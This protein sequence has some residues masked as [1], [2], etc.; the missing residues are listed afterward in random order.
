MTVMA[1][2]LE[3][4]WPLIVD[5]WKQYAKTSSYHFQN[6]TEA[7]N[8]ALHFAGA[9]LIQTAVEFNMNSTEMYPMTE[10]VLSACITLFTNKQRVLE[11]AAPQQAKST[12]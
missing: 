8:K 6:S 2:R 3:V 11:M 9:R 7:F 1:E 12:K 5:F 4:C 10:D